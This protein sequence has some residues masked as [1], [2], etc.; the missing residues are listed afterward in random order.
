MEECDTCTPQ[1][2]YANHPQCQAPEDAEPIKVEA[3]CVEVEP[4]ERVFEVSLC[5]NDVN[6]ACVVPGRD[7]WEISCECAQ[8][9]ANCL[10]EVECP[11]AGV[12]LDACAATCSRDQCTAK[13]GWRRP[14]VNPG[15]AKAPAAARRLSPLLLLLLVAPFFR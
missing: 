12:E 10:G 8:L 13:Q 15:P 4:C 3:K 14:D 6:A 7:P 5:V 2:C 1:V 9:T 11:L